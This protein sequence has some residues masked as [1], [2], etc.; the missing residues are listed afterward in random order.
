MNKKVIKV[1]IFTL[2]WLFMFINVNAQ[3]YSTKDLIEA[4]SIA[5]VKTTTFT[6]NNIGYIY[7]QNTNNSLFH[8]DSVLNNTNKTKPV[9]IN[10]LLFDSEKKNIG[11]LTYCTEKD[12]D[13][14]YAQVELK[15]NES[16]GFEIKVLDRYFVEGYS[17]KN[18][19]Y[20]SIYDD[21]PYC[22]IGGYDKYKELTIE[23]IKSGKVNVDKTNSIQELIDLIDSLDYRLL[24]VYIFVLIITYIVTGIF[25][26]ELNKKMNAASSPI[27]Y[28]PI[29]NNYLAMKLAF[30]TMIASIYLIC[31]FISFVLFIFGFRFVNYILSIISSIAFIIDII[32][33]I[34][35][36]YNLFLYEPVTS[37]YLESNKTVRNKTIPSPNNEPI[38]P[39]PVVPKNTGDEIIDL[40]YADPVPEGTLPVN[41]TVNTPIDNTSN[42][43]DGN[44]KDDDGETELSDLFK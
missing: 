38:I 16:T 36:K 43:N 29:G 33:L 2:V 20:Y 44:K 1:V 11:F 22:H 18:I 14:S 19:A 39:N 17:S 24:F 26:N 4:N 31:L 34:T 9:S 7:D 21:N 32:K 27:A 25:L 35:K 6:Y 5:T 41:T 42:S 12:L 40:N 15:G 30:G 37:N 10:I 28:I 13:S 3:D 23:Q 8:F